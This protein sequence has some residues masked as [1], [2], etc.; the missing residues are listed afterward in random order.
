MTNPTATAPTPS[1]VFL[2]SGGARGI[3]AR[4]V[5]ELATRFGCSFALLGRTAPVEPEPAWAIGCTD[6][7]ELKRRIIAALRADGERPLP[8][9]AERI[10]QRLVASREISAT[11]AALERAG[12][13][14]AYYAAD[15]ADPTAVRGVVE[16]ASARLG[17]IDGLLHGA[18]S[19]ADRLIQ[20]KTAADFAKVYRPKVDGLINLLRC[21]PPAQ[22]R[23]LILFS[24]VAAHYGNPGQADYALANAALD[25]AAHALARAH[26]TC[27][28]LALDWG[29][30]DGGMVSPALGRLFR[31]RGLELIGLEAGARL[32]A[33]L[34]GRPGHGAVQVLVGGP[35]AGSAGPA[36]EAQPGRTVRVARRLTL[37]DNPFLADHVLD[38]H[39]TLP[40]AAVMTWLSNAAEQLWP[41]CRLER[42]EACQVLKGVVLDGPPEQPVELQLELREVERA[43]GPIRLAAEISSGPASDQGRL[44]YRAGLILGPGEST[45]DAPD[46]P[47]E[48]GRSG[49]VAAA[50]TSVYRD[51]TLFHGPRFQGIRR[52]LDASETRLV[53]E[54]E[55]PAVPVEEQGQFTVGSCDPFALD[56]AFQALAVWSRQF[57]GAASLPTR[58]GSL[59]LVRP[60]PSGRRCFVTA[61]IRSAGDGQVIADVLLHDGGGQP[62]YRLLEVEH[63]VSPRL[64]ERFLR[65]RLAPPEP[66]G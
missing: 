18:G 4:C 25:Q 30:W 49:P 15:V 23:H 39:A 37:A 24:S 13:R 17:P 5:V 52:V 50:D 57:R 56:L 2:V 55:A 63:T 32:L 62:Y 12:S 48:S 22:L 44:R 53:L 9:T 40:L 41:G 11:L 26:P 54:C 7:P 14:A 36:V 38:G 66:A 43:D 61:E 29:P 28:V 46:R 31:E 47:P 59:E 34:L 6:E 45:A 27:R 51:G 16:A 3:T 21:V 10:Y 58:V 65:N 42:V 19:L 33:D 35:L 20:D 8:L 64:N 1:S 60:V